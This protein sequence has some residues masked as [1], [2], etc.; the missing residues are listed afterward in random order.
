MS[1]GATGLCR[2]KA[3]LR[4]IFLFIDGAVEKELNVNGNI[5]RSADYFRAC[6]DRR[7]YSVDMHGIRARNYIRDVFTGEI[8][9]NRNRTRRLTVSALYRKLKEN[10]RFKL[11]YLCPG[12]V[13]EYRSVAPLRVSCEE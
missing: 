6:S 10:R 3:D 13:S 2:W 12:N 4:S 9:V 1:V 8:R 7:K 5:I 11:A